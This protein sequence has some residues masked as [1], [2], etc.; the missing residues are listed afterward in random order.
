[1]LAAPS[2]HTFHRLNRL[3]TTFLAQMWHVTDPVENPGA[4]SAKQPS[5]DDQSIANTDST[6]PEDAP[7]P[8]IEQVALPHHNLEPALSSVSIVH[9]DGQKNTPSVREQELPGQRSDQ[10]T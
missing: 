3:L 1:M 6:H 9:N 7:E 4:V 5:T 10:S 8:P 2:H